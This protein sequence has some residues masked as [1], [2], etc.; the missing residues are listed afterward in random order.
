MSETVILALLSV[1]T[2]VNIGL[3]YHNIRLLKQIQRPDDRK[4]KNDEIVKHERHDELLEELR[5]MKVEYQELQNKIRRQSIDPTVRFDFNQNPITT[6]PRLRVWG[7]DSAFVSE[8]AQSG[9]LEF[10]ARD[11]DKLRVNSD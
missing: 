6:E 3:L 1:I 4:R 7:S 11:F 8:D 10:D 2:G 5:A 9:V